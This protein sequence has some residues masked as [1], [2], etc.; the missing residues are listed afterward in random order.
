MLPAE[1]NYPI[2]DKEML[3]IMT[4]LKEWRHFLIGT[5]ESFE[6]WS[7]HNNIKHYH[8]PQDLNRRQ[9]QWVTTMAEYNFTLHH[10]AGKLNTTTNVLSRRADHLPSQPKNQQVTLLKEEWFR[11]IPLSIMEPLDPH[12]PPQTINQDTEQ[13]NPL[14]STLEPLLAVPPTIINVKELIE[15]VIQAQ[16]NHPAPTRGCTLQ[17]GVW[18]T[19]LGQYWVPQ[20][21]VLRGQIIFN[22]HD[23]PLGGHPRRKTILTNIKKTFFWPG[24]D[25]QLSEYCKACIRCQELKNFPPPKSRYPSPSQHS[26]RT[27]GSHFD[28]C[29]DH[30]SKYLISTPITVNLTSRQVAEIYKD[31]VFSIFGVPKKIMS[32]RG[33]QF[34][35]HFMNDI[36]A[37]CKI[38]PNR[39]TA[40]HPQTNKQ[41]ERINAEITKYLQLYSNHAQNDWAEW[42]LVA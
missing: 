27:L 1:R 34:A 11:H 33:T 19:N 41:V 21:P 26:P 9:A 38:T 31:K 15:Q 3:A 8:Q 13:A 17:E 16:A 6:I 20:D 7:D 36:L 40:Y 4:A 12:N 28:R 29:V 25:R 2:Y 14:R 10:L 37:A 32:D 24:L 42:L 5:K 23:H 18:L 35:S 39:S 30:F 22:A